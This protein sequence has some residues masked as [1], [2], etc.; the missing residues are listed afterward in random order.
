VVLYFINM[1]DYPF[2]SFGLVRPVA[3]ELFYEQ[4]LQGLPDPPAVSAAAP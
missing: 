1:F 3:L 2:S 4:F